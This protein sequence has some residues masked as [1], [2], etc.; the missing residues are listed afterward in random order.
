[1]RGKCSHRERHGVQ[2]ENK[3]NKLRMI[4]RSI[5]KERREKQRDEHEE[6]K[7]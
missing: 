6:V 7:N 5:L 1:M 3:R 4:L 2:K